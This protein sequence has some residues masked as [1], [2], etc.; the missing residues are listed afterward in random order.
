[1]FGG[2]NLAFGDASFEIPSLKG[3]PLTFILWRKE[4]FPASTNILYDASA[5]D[6]FPTEDLAVLG[7]LS[8][9]RLIKAST[10]LSP[11]P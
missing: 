5:N 4:E 7:E 3:I 10:N 9:L 8:T 11:M 2:N 6:Y 1:M